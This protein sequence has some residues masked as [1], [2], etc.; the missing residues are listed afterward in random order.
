M[1]SVARASALYLGR[2]T[3]PVSQHHFVRQFRQKQVTASFEAEKVDE[4]AMANSAD[5]RQAVCPNSSR[6]DPRMIDDGRTK[7]GAERVRAL[8]DAAADMF[9]EH[10]YDAMSLDALI[11]RVGGSR[12]N[13]YARFGGKEGLFV[14][15]I[16]ELGNELMKSVA[17]LRIELE[18][19]RSGLTHFANS[20]LTVILHPRSLALHRLMVAEGGR[21]PQL[22]QAIYRA[23]PANAARA[24]ATWIEARQQ[25]GRL[26]DDVPA[27]DLADKFIELLVPGPQLRALVGHD[28]SPMSNERLVR[29]VDQTVDIFLYGALAPS[30]SGPLG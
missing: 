27:P 13:I 23:G 12:R 11:A 30:P 25:R 5:P 21:T 29:Y 15:V 18:D 9:L 20:I 8:L 2:R 28:P 19:E 7:R 10:G 1:F 6:S 17:D 26:R 4:Q 24:L 22:A 16:G 3:N 14:E